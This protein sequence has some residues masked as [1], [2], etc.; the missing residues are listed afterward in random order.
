MLNNVKQLL[1]QVWRDGVVAIAAANIIHFLQG[2]G[3]ESRLGRSHTSSPNCDGILGA[4]QQLLGGG[5]PHNKFLHIVVWQA[6][7]WNF[8]L[9]YYHLI[10]SKNQT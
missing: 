5:S 4:A 8:T 1:H 7:K 2:H 10:A 3:F 9:L 6:N